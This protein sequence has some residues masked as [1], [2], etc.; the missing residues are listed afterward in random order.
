MDPV[1]A[2][3]PD[4]YRTVAIV[5]V[6]GFVASAPWVVGVMWPD[7][8]CASTWTAALV[9]ISVTMLAI[10]LATG[11]VL[12]DIG[13]RIETFMDKR[14]RVTLADFEQTWWEYLRL[15]CDGEVVAQRYLRSTLTRFKFELSMV[16]AATIC[17][18]GIFVAQLL[19]HGIGWAKTLGLT[20]L[21]AALAPFLYLE[22]KASVALLSR[23]R[24]EIVKARV[25]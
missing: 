8:Q 16:P 18:V 21:L 19:G 24:K 9:P 23:V 7:L 2:L 5:L 11:I 22:A 25:S 1:T 20:V 12:E 14:L 4:V 10:V 6:P 3:K 17:A 15:P 13:S